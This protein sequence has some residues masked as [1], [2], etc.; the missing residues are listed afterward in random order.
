MGEKVI[1]VHVPVMRWDISTY[2]YTCGMG[3]NIN[4]VLISFMARNINIH[5]YV[6]IGYESK[7][8]VLVLT[9]VMGPGDIYANTHE[10]CIK[11]VV[12]KNF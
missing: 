4:V 7:K 9:V 3:Q 6:Y 10:N 8:L 1:T 2:C 11:K 12:I 5:V